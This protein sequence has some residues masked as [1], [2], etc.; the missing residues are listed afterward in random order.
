M[1]CHRIQGFY[2]IGIDVIKLLNPSEYRIEVLLPV[3][4]FVFF[5]CDAC[6]A[7][8]MADGF[9]IDGHDFV[10][11]VLGR[12]MVLT[13]EINEMETFIKTEG[14]ICLTCCKEGLRLLALDYG[15][16]RTGIAVSDKAWRVAVPFGVIRARR[17]QLIYRALAERLQSTPLGGFILGYPLSCDGRESAQSVRVRRFADGLVRFFAKPVVLVDERYSSLAAQRLLQSGYG[18]KQARRLRARGYQDALAATWILQAVLDSHQ[19][20]S[21]S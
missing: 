10:L 21:L 14:Q 13:F 9:S 15:G 8:D 16:A 3:F 18:A 19:R 12:F 6:E 17:H 11:L 5:D 2:R 20:M 7:G 1:V 4:C